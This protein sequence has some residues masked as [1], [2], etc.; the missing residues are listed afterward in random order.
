MWGKTVPG[1][2]HVSGKIQHKVD[3]KGPILPV[4]NT[5]GE[6]CLQGRVKPFQSAIGLG[7]IGRSSN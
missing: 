1:I 5:F 7:M 3:C 2:W 4:L 6:H